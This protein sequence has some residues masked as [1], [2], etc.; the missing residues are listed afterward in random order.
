MINNTKHK[1]PKVSKIE[2]IEMD[3][4]A[5]AKTTAKPDAVINLNI[6]YLEKVINILKKDNVQYIDLF[7][8]GSDK[9][10]CFGER[11][12]KVKEGIFIAPRIPN[13]SFGKKDVRI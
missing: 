5:K 4:I 6:Y 3:I 1:F 8:F 7:V 13:Y 2:D 12:G 10:I 9:P 11:K